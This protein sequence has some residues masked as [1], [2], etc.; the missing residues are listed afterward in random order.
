MDEFQ[1]NS[2]L[3]TQLLQLMV[4]EDA[5]QVTLLAPRARARPHP[6]TP[7]PLLPPPYPHLDRHPSPQLRPKP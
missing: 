1:D 7:T 2:G 4:H 3:Q 5:P 6:L